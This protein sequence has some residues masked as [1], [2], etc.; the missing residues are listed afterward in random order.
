MTLSSLWVMQLQCRGTYSYIRSAGIVNPA[1][2]VGSG[3]GLKVYR[4]R[5]D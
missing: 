4:G 1:E 2:L 3:T 5:G